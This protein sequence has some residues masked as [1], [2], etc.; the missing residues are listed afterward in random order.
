MRGVGDVSEALIVMIDPASAQPGAG[1]VGLLL[2]A[3]RGE[4]FDAAVPGGKLEQVIDGRSVAEHALMALLASCDA[5]IVAV[6]SF[7]SAFARRARELGA[8]L[9]VP[10][11]ATLGMGHSLAA[12]AA[13]ATARHGGTRTLVVALADMPW[14][15]ADTV[16]ALV[17]ASQRRDAIV[18]PEFAGERGHPVVF[19]VAFADAL[20]ACRGDVGA[21]ELLRREATRVVALAVA[22][23]GVLRDVDT[24]ED[25]PGSA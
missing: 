2:A 19:P 24:R 13:A 6:R 12:L 22:D 18:Q 21:R 15:Q 1:V 14:V 23:S 25:L 11:E 10:T 9:L 5:V 3:G 20:A 16:R 8:E 7:D 17:D 4:R